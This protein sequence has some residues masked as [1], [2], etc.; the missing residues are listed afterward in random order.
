M[1][2]HVRQPNSHVLFF[3]IIKD[4]YL[5]D[6]STLLNA[7]CVN[8]CPNANQTVSCLPDGVNCPASG[9]I[10]SSYDTFDVFIFCAPD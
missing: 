6:N 7:I 9:Q 10:T 5:V 4:G 3:L 2:Q 1:E 8:T